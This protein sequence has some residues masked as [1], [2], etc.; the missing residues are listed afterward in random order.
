MRLKLALF[1]GFVILCGPVSAAT[2]DAVQGQAAVNRGHGFEAIST[3][4]EVKPGDTVMVSPGSS[5]KIVYPDRCTVE[6][7]PNGAV[8]IGAQSPCR[9]R[10]SLG[11][12]CENADPKE[13]CTPAPW[14]PGVAPFVVGTGLALGGFLISRDNDDGGGRRPRSP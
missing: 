13:L 2:V 6:V 11:N 1:S 14:R 9:A 5:A 4:A 12:N 7:H 8:A 10:Y 3:G